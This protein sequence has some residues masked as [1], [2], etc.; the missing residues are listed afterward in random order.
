MN[1]LFATTFGV[2]DMMLWYLAYYYTKSIKQN[3]LCI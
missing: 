3:G 1:N 2:Y